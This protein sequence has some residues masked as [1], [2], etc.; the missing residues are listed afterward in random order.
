MHLEIVES[1]TPVVG[2][3]RCDQLI[4]TYSVQSIVGVNDNVDSVKSRKGMRLP[5]QGV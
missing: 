1:D 2:V 5:E 4:D 3:N